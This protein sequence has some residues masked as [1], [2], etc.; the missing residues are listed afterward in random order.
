MGEAES[1]TGKRVLSAKKLP[2]GGKI[3]LIVGGAVLALLVG[4]YLGLCAYVKGSDVILPR[5][6]A[7]GVELGG[8]NGEQA[9]AKL[10]EEIDR[11]LSGQRVTFTYPGGTGQAQGA[12]LEVDAASTAASAFQLGREGGFLGGGGA[13]LAA[14]FGGHE[15]AA[16]IRF[17]QE[18]EREVGDLVA[19]IEDHLTHKVEETSYRL[20]ENDLAL[21]KGVSGMGIDGEGVKEKILAA[22]EGG[23]GES[24]SPAFDVEPQITA[25]AEPDFDAIYAEIYVE[26]ADAYLDKTTK[27]IIPSIVGVTFDI[28]TAQALLERAEE[29]AVCEVPISKTEPKITTENLQAN[30]FKDVLGN[31]KSYASG[32]ATRRANIKLAASFLNGII[33]LPGETFS[34]NAYCEP[35]TKANGYQDAGTYQN[36]KSVDATA[37][38]ICQLSSTLYWATLEAN[39]ETVERT[40]HGY[41]TGYLS[42]VGTDATVFA[43]SPDFKFKNS[44]DYPV[45]IEAYLD[46]GN[47]VHVTLYG[48]SNGVRGVPFNKVLAT[49]P[50][51]TKY[52][53]KAAVPQGSKPQKDT[54]Q[55]KIDGIT[56]EVYLRLVDA[57]GNTVETK[58]LH[59]D[60]YAKRD[61][62]YYYNPADA[63]L[64]GID[65]AT[66]LKTLSPIAPSPSPSSSVSPSVSPSTTPDSGATTDPG[67]SPEPSPG[68]TVEP[69]PSV[70]PSGS[71]PPAPSVEPSPSPSTSPAESTPASPPVSTP[72]PGIPT[73]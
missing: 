30:L 21:I 18:G 9:Q 73:N 52:V 23:K 10:T 66:G 26:A 47:N 29:G 16:P 64:W 51:V 27:E 17:S 13:Y 57:N 67:I 28:P 58:F 40:Q 25:P 24:D 1:T 2:L 35:Y 39:L 38:G 8:L 20:Q 68:A 42:I 59:K 5:T 61:G 3:A 65:P 11:R 54:E 71:V 53:A 19:E 31:T 55:Y 37:G 56:V 6:T 34:Y 12:W 44:T 7:S 46:S 69:S 41:N 50:A 49:N 60:S 48:T 43:G 33:L 72:P 36:G 22:F 14:F 45:K 15:V 62:V 70:T 32:P 4:G 63:A